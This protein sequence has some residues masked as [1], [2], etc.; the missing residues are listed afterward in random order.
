MFKKALIAI[1]LCCLSIFTIAQ[2]GTLSGKITSEDGFP[3]EGVSIVDASSNKIYGF[4]GVDGLYEIKL[5]AGRE[6]RVRFSYVGYENKFIKENL[7]E[8]EVKNRNIIMVIPSSGAVQIFGI[9]ERENPIKKIPVKVTTEIPSFQGGIEAVLII[10]PVNMTNELSSAY[11]VRGGSFDENLVYVNEIEVYRPFLVRSGRQEGLSFP[12]P[13]MVDN[14]VFSAGGFE[15]KYGD[16]LSSV[17]DINYKNPTEFHGAMTASLLGGSIQIGNRRTLGGEEGNGGY[18]SHNTGVRYRSNAY[19]LGTLDTQG[20]YNPNFVDVQSYMTWKPKKY[21]TVEYSFLGNYSR[22]NYNF[23][24]QTRQTDVGTINEALRF[25]VFF[26]GQENSSFETFFGAFSTKILTA[27]ESYLRFTVSAFNTYENESFDVLGQYRL[28]ELERDFGSDEFGEVIRNRGIGA[29]REHARNDLDATVF[30]FSHRGS[31]QVNKFNYL[32]WGFRAQTENIDDR[33]SEWTMID[34]AGY[35]SP[36]P[37]DLIGYDPENR[38]DQGI[39]L[40]DVIKSEN[41]L[42]SFRSSAYI[43]NRKS[44]KY[45]DNSEMTLT[46]GLRGTHWTFNNEFVG[47][48]RIQYSYKPNWV[49]QT[50]SLEKKRDVVFTL[51][52]GFYYQPAFY[53]ELR[54]LD[55]TLNEEIE[56]QRAIHFVAGADYLFQLWERDFKLRGEVYYKDLANLIP[57][58]VENVRT[59]YY[60][61]NNANGY[62]TGADL[63]MNGEFIEGVQSW[64]RASLLFTAEDLTD[65][66][67]FEYIN[68]DGEV[69]EPGFTLNTEVADSTLVFPGNIPRPTD[70]RF[71]FSMIFQDQMRKWPHYKVLVSMFY[72]TGLPYGPPDFERYKDVLRLPAYRRVDIGFSRDLF[73]KR[74]KE[75]PFFE[76]GMISLEVFNILDINNTN[77]YTWVE[78]VNGRLYGISNFLTGRRLNLRLRLT[79]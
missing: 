43:Q 57:Y 44:W 64:L 40:Q 19:V 8:G 20:E 26:E 12:N 55:G 47:G 59:R 18:F 56:A 22:N 3:L 27:E 13:D 5:D 39:F 73:V 60:A 29:F 36:R 48:P 65:D 76:T 50:D 21:G 77:N 16:K 72:S 15:A 30:N 7:E 52:G 25:T 70:Q 31:S 45:E 11:S 62:A 69:I 28:D 23:T 74:D 4:S 42:S 75:D 63:M 35:N 17:L 14:I 68:T 6:I 61:T 78:D 33:L 10:A 2:T 51:A 34:S 67:Y 49:I 54:G 41:S 9:K 37:N 58:E 53:K 66:S 79:F 46:L 32:E 24:P 38:P 71:S 1:S